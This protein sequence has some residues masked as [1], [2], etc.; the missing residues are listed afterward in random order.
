MAPLHQPARAGRARRRR[1]AGG[2]SFRGGPLAPVGV[3]VS[4]GLDSGVLVG[5]LLRSARVQPIYVRSGL[6]WEPVERYWLRRYLRALAAPALQ[7]LVELLEPAGDLYGRHWSVSGRGVPGYDAALD[8]NYLPGRNL[9]L[10]G[11]VTVF[12]ALHG[13]DTLALAL[14]RD[15]PFPDGRAE[16]FRCFAAAARAALEMNVRIRLPF[17]RLS[18]AAV[19]RRARGL[20]L[21]LT[22]SCAR[23]VGRRHCGACTKCAERHRAFQAAGCADPTPY[24]RQPA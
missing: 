22:V 10:L 13:I 8:S 3:L 12:C 11:K 5:E 24:S 18:K 19:I 21:A 17:R 4:G 16:F 20:P 7:P 2:R 15:N 9:L 23:P 14:L 1:G 6:I